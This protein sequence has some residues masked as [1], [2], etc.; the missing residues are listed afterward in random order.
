MPHLGGTPARLAAQI[1]G[2]KARKHEWTGKVVWQ[3][4]GTLAWSDQRIR[5]AGIDP[6]TWRINDRR[7]AAFAWEQLRTGK[8]KYSRKRQEM[9]VSDLNNPVPD[10]DA[11]LIFSTQRDNLKNK[12]EKPTDKNIK[13]QIINY[14]RDKNNI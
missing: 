1:I 3:I 14:L 10:L 6:V 8:R 5:S 13:T 4:N 11:K 7:R 9:L 12:E 2:V